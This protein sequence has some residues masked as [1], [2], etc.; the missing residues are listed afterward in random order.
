[1]RLPHTVSREDKLRLMNWRNLAEAALLAGILGSQSGLAALADPCCV[2]SSRIVLSSAEVPPG[3]TVGDQSSDLFQRFFYA[4]GTPPGAV[5]FIVSEVHPTTSADLASALVNDTVRSA[6]GAPG[7]WTEAG[8]YPAIGDQSV[9]LLGSNGVWVQVVFR[10]ANYFLQVRDW[11]NDCGGIDA[12]MARAHKMDANLSAL[13]GPAPSLPGCQ[14]VLGFKAV[15][16]AIPAIVGECLDNQGFAPNG[17]SQQHTTNGLLAWRKADNWTAFTD[18]Y[19]TWLI[20]P[21]GLQ[22][23]LNSERF[24]WEGDYH[25]SPSVPAS[26][27]D[28]VQFVGSLVARAGAPVPDPANGGF[29]YCSPAPILVGSDCAITDRLRQRLAVIYSTSGGFDWVCRC[30][31]TAP[32]TATSIDASP[33]QARVL[34]SYAWRPT[35]SNI[36]F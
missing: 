11:C 8:P 16:D 23:R 27:P 2:D 14:F 13:L 1:M 24:P 15:H 30:Q 10:R 19:R 35:P 32:T 22:Q 36:V 34:V 26:A 6:K 29:R 9:V 4:P 25:P 33:N 20:G 5:N 12:A 17:D 31:N 28:P 3:W 21:N 7:F 18:G